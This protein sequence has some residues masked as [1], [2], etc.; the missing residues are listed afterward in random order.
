MDRTLHDRDIREPLLLFME[1]KFGRIR[2]IEEKTVGRSRADIIMVTDSALYGIEIKSDAD[3][4][5]RLSRQTRDYDRFC[6]YNYAAVGSSHAMHISEHI[7]AHWGIITVEADGDRLDFYELREPRP[8]PNL[9]PEKKIA[10]LW[11]PE[12]AH[13]Q[14]RNGLPKYTE[15]SKKFVAGKILEKVPPDILARQISDELFERDYTTVEETI[16]AYRRE[17][18]HHTKKKRRRKRSG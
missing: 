6:D 14:E 10:L 16:D 12:L 5:A 4:Y 7:P 18:S 3:T 11:R 13:I 9:D 17:H 2:M 15:K 1:E 8:N